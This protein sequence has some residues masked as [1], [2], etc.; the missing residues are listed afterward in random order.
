MIGICKLC[1]L[2][3]ELC[4]SHIIPEFFY[5]PLYD[6]DHKFI[7]MNLEPSA[8]KMKRY[9]YKGIWEQ[10]LCKECELTL[11]KYEKYASEIWK[12]KF[13]NLPDKFNNLKDIDYVAFKL[14]LISI[15]WRCSV[16]NAKSFSIDLGIHQE[17][18]RRMIIEGNP[19]KYDEYGC[20]ISAIFYNEEELAKD[21]VWPLEDFD[22]EEFKCYRL[23]FGGFI[24]MFLIPNIHKE[25]RSKLQFYIT[26]LFLQESNSLIIEVV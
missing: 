18:M 19:G 26:K 7:R 1:H 21:L 4:D 25:S 13:Q 14:F 20:I 5:K 11:S 23:G 9:I 15:I 16:T 3:K 24:W 8:L 2:Q 10:L 12:S 17:I 6:K 22:L